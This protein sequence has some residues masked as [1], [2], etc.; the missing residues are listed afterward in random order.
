MRA[1]GLLVVALSVLPA[2]A[3]AQPETNPRVLFA[4]GEASFDRGRYEE[5][6]V[7]FAAAYA[8]TPL[9]GFLFNIAQCHRLL[10]HFREAADNY[11][12]YLDEVPAAPN[13]AEAEA[14]LA[15]VNAELAR[16]AAPAAPSPTPTPP[17]ERVAAPPRV[18]PEP[19]PPRP[20]RSR[21]S[22]GTF[23]RPVAWVSIGAGIA[24]AVGSTLFALR[25]EDRQDAFDDP[26]LDCHADRS[27][28]LT[29]RDE[30]R[31]AALWANVLGASAIVFVAAG[32]VLHLL[33]P[34]HDEPIEPVLARF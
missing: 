6:L 19:S 12:R 23:H 25:L 28:C 7:D 20:P 17:R 22:G 3:A 10:G 8:M 33:A 15:Q 13:R 21:R 27:R 1:C 26:G 31:S 34:S 5:A 16:T 24:L 14:L 11:R 32:I 2:V 30:G 29:I 18:E 9:P 4:R